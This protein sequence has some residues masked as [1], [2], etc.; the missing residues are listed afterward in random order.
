M[1]RMGMFEAFGNAKNTVQG[2]AL[3]VFISLALAL[4]FI[5]VSAFASEGESDHPDAPVVQAESA[6][7]KPAANPEAA[8]AVAG[9]EEPATATELETAPSEKAPQ[10]E[11]GSGGGRNH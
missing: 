6:A 8:D 7:D 5:N 4:S 11:S 2:K 1:I 10:V 9:A 3:A